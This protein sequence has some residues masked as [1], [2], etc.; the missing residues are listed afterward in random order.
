MSVTIKRIAELAGVSV[1][2]VD[3][4]INNRG[5]VSKDVE[6][7]VNSIIKEL[8]YKPNLT[9]TSLSIRRKHLKLGIIFHTAYN[10]FNIEVQKGIKEANKNKRDLDITILERTVKNFDVDEQLEAIDE[11]VGLEVF[12]IAIVPINN[13]RVAKKIDDLIEKGVFIYCFVNDIVTTHPHPFVGI[14]N[15]KAGQLAAG[16]FSMFAKRNETKKL[17]IITPSMSMLGHEKRIRGVM[18]TISKNYKNIEIAPLCQIPNG[19]IEIYKTVMEYFKCNKDISMIWYATS[20]DEGGIT[21]LRELNLLETEII[22]AVD[23]PP[24]VKE[25]LDKRDIIATISQDPFSQ[26]YQTISTIYSDLIQKGYYTSKGCEVPAEILL[27]E[28]MKKHIR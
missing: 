14:D 26:G 13:E 5:R 12:A 25:A 9:A 17:A 2:S 21:A 27:K 7:K 15:Y 10:Y 16:F 28:N 4:V 1:G 11:M 23:L 20:L 3:R 24:F 18:E 19:Q 8:D 6:E 22:L